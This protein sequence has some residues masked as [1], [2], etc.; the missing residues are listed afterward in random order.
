MR[1]TRMPNALPSDPAPPGR[2][3]PTGASL[4]VPRGTV[5]VRAAGARRKGLVRTQQEGGHLQARKS[6]TRT[7]PNSTLILDFQPQ[8]CEKVNVCGV[9]LWRP[10]LTTTSPVTLTGTSAP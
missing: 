5:D 7:N 2:I 3:Y 8:K 6:L 4:Q 9:W 1:L 10:E